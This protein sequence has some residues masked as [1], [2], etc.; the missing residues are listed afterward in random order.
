MTW[1]GYIAISTLAYST[2][3]LIQRVL[4]QEN[5]EYPIAFIVFYQTLV[6]IIVLA[7]GFLRGFLSFPLET[8][9]ELWLPIVLAFFLYAS[10]NYCI[11]ASLERIPASNFTIAFSSRMFF[12][13]IAAWLLL[14][15]SLNAVQ[16]GGAALIFAGIVVANF[17]SHAKGAGRSGLLFAVLGAV[18]FGLANVNDRFILQ[19]MELYSYVGL[20]FLGTAL[21]FAVFQT[22]K[23]L[24]GTSLL[25][26][27][28]LRKI[29]V[30]SLFYAISSVTFFA[31]LQIGESASQ[32]VSV[33]LVSVIVTVL[34]AMI[35]LKEREHPYQKL[36]GAALS[37]IGVLL[38]V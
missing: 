36:L 8:I 26:P 14:G 2:A 33:S 29:A 30:L 32:V 18:F 24:A 16:Y 6:G 34:F 7:Y 21:V 17:S 20:S 1:V 15:E 11:F 12:T 22:K 38:L 37:F 31:A 9:T 5:K 13:A 4:V 10:A 27:R 19:S 23:L 35:F 25:R 28:P 3:V